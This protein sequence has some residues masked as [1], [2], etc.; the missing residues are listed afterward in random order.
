MHVFCINCGQDCVYSEKTSQKEISVRGIWF[1]Y[2]ERSAFCTACGEEVYVPAINDGNV[3]RREEAYK[4]TRKIF[5]PPYQ[6]YRREYIPNQSQSEMCHTSD[7][8]EWRKDFPE[9]GELRFDK[10]SPTMLRHR[11][12]KLGENPQKHKHDP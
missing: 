9:N 5:A 6:G 3:R 12:I 10:S 11:S 4:K 2:L 7:P 8:D 1:S